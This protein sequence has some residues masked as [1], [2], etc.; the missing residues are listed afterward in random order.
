MKLKYSYDIKKTREI[1]LCLPCSHL[2]CVAGPQPFSF[3][4]AI[5]K[6][7]AGL[8][9]VS[10]CAAVRLELATTHWAEAPQK[11]LTKAN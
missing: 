9:V 3:L 5:R 6:I 8:V 2:T 4:A 11:T 1:K 10:M 7:I